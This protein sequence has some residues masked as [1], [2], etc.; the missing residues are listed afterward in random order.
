[1]KQLE[2]IQQEEDMLM[3]A[4]LSE[5]QNPEVLDAVLKLLRAVETLNDSGIIDMLTTM[6]DFMAMYPDAINTDEMADKVG[7][8][9]QSH[10]GLIEEAKTIRP[11]NLVKLTRIMSRDQVTEP[12]MAMIQAVESIEDVKGLQDLLQGLAKVTSRLSG[13]SI[14]QVVEAMARPRVLDALPKLVLLLEAVNDRGVFD[15]LLLA[16]DYLEEL[17]T[18]LPS[19]DVIDQIFRWI[20]DNHLLESMQSTQWQNL[21]QM[22]ALASQNEMTSL[23]TLTLNTL[24]DIPSAT[25]QQLLN[26]SLDVLGFIDKNQGWDVVRQVLGAADA[27]KSEVN[28]GGLF[29]GLMTKEGQINVGGIVDTIKGVAEDTQKK[30]STFGGMRGMMAMM[31]DPDVQKGLQFMTAALG[32]LVHMAMTPAS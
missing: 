20:Q 26:V 5:A 3:D 22:A 31:K 4:V 15:D 9:Y 32:R 14:V 23:L 6:V 13:E 24:K 12:L 19:G 18:L 7:Q 11:E 21:I 27:L 2:I 10:E 17:S 8:Y 25:I 29:P 28:W 16:V 1:M 30:T